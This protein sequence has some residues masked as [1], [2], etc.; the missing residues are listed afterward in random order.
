VKT[1]PATAK[2]QALMERP[3]CKAPTS[4]RPH[5]SCGSDDPIDGRKDDEESGNDEGVIHETG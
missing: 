3:A 1:T 2:T 4:K 5:E